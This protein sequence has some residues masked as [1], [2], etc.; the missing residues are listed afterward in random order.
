MELDK[1][2]SSSNFTGFAILYDEFRRRERSRWS[3]RGDQSLDIEKEAWV[4]DDEILKSMGTHSKTTL[5]AAGLASAESS[6]DSSRV[7]ATLP[8]LASRES[9]LANQPAVPEHQTKKFEAE[10]RQA[11]FSSVGQNR[12]GHGGTHNRGSRGSGKQSSGNGNGGGKASNQNVH[13][14]SNQRR[15]RRVVPRTP[16]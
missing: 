9:A 11:G 4:V 6:V 10:R 12:F 15:G 1:R 8:L 3:E 7:V 16:A 2:A 14:F 13:D 5:A